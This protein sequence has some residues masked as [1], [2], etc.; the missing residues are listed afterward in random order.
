V[1][2]GMAVAMIDWMDAGRVGI[3]LRI[4][5]IEDAEARRED[6]PAGSVG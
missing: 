4:D 3:P 1:Y 6:I 2:N 5:S